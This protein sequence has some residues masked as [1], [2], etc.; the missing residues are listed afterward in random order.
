MGVKNARLPNGDG[1][2]SSTGSHDANTLQADMR[3]YA[4]TTIRDA[5]NPKGTASYMGNVNCNTPLTSA[6]PN[7]VQILLADGAVRVLTDNVDLT[8]YKRLADR[9]DGNAIGDF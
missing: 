1:T 3:S 6:H 2:W 8:T 9:D 7:G 4:M 5:P